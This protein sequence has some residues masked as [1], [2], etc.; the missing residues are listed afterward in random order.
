MITN[1]ASAPESLIAP[2][3]TILKD[4][5]SCFSNEEPISDAVRAEIKPGH[6]AVFA[7]G[8][9]KYR[10]A[11]GIDRETRYRRSWNDIR[12]ADGYGGNCGDNG[13][14]KDK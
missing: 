12:S 5:G 13:C 2:A 3:A 1:S 9:M 7:I 10:D 4:A 8:V 14:P 6:K 11:F